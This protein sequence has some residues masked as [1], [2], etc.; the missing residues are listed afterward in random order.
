MTHTALVPDV[1]HIVALRPNGIGDFMFAL[2]ALHALRAAYPEARLT[3]LGKPWHA[4]FLQER[5]GPVD[6]VLVMPPY[7]GVG[8]PPDT[9]LGQEAIAFIERLREQQ[10]CLAVQMYGGGRHSNAFVN[11]LEARLSIGART[12]DAATLD[13]WIPYGPF[14]NRR[15]ELLQVV[16]LAGAAPWIGSPELSITARDRAS[17]QEAL[18]WMP[19][20]RIVILHPGASDPRRHWPAARFAAVADALAAKG[21]QIVISATG[22]EAEVARTVL[23]HMRHRALDLTDRLSLPGLCGLLERAELMLANDTGPLHLALA[24]GKPAV[25]IFWLTNLIE[26]GPLVPHL[27]RPAMSARVHCPVCGAENRKTRCPHNPC[28]VDDVSTE[29]V[30]ELALE[31]FDSVA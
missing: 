8:A 16:A 1:R 21:A 20:E 17:A 4:D 26:A 3:L 27:L 11:L 22:S 24:L 31:L 18:P 29:T 13:R 25:G 14:A 15:L 5:A 10:A 2:P 23:A 7:P 30:M 28:F 12:P 19:G 9:P 6:E